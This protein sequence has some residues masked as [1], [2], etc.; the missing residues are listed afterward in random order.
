ML[1]TSRHFLSLP[2]IF[3]FLDAMAYNKFNVMHWHIVDEV[4]FPWDSTTYPLLAQKGA[5][6]AHHTYTHENVKDVVNYAAS[7][8]IR[9]IPEFDTP[10]HTRS[11][12]VG[13]PELLTPCYDNGKPT[14]K[15]YA[16][17]PIRNE[18]YTFVSNVFKEARGLWF[19][20]YVHVGGD[21]V[22]FACWESNPDIQA[23]MKEKGWTD[24]KLLEQYY[25]NTLLELLG[26]MGL[27]Y[28]CWE[29]VF[30]NGVKI[31]P[32]TV[33]HVWRGGAWNN[34]IARSTAAG[35]RSILSSPWYLNY[36]SYGSDWHNYYMTEPLDFKGTDEQKKLVFGGE[37]CLWAEYI[38]DTNLISRAWPRASSVG[39]R[40][41]SAES[42]KDVNEATP[43]LNAMRCR[44]IR[45]G[46][47]AEPPS[48][49]GFCGTEYQDKYVAPWNKK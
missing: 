42:V 19:D 11:W 18:S 21:E 38:D 34:T 17:N 33:V 31:L 23:W 14:G 22:S 9:V 46:L 39:E 28:I 29:D 24:Y 10:G 5:W 30:D 26:K 16:V 41:W 45:R 3:E 1:D 13:Y 25:E 12:G 47:N 32:D 6:D 48:G 4:A 44:M 43:R 2:T 35:Y 40:L 37:V 8:G 36:I 15:R 49:P 20:D 27:K 7:W